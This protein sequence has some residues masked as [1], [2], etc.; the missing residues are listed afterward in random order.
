M[1]LFFATRREGLCELCSVYTNSVYTNCIRTA[2]FSS[3]HFFSDHLILQKLDK[4]VKPG[5]DAHCT[6]PDLS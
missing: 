2:S 1:G 4:Q 5:R 3:D 6:R